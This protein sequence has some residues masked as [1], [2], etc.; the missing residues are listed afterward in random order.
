M[1]EAFPVVAIGGSVGGLLSLLAIVRRLPTGFPGAILVVIHFPAGQI[2]HLD[3]ILT[4]EGSLPATVAMDHEAIQPGHIYVAP[5]DGCHLVVE[6]GRLHL[7]PGAK[8]HRFRPAIDP[9]FRSAAR[10]FGSR[11]AGVLLSGHNR[12]GVGGLQSVQA[13]GGV[14]IVQDPAEATV[15]RLPDAALA[16]MHVDHCSSAAEIAQHLDRWA[17]ARLPVFTRGRLP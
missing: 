8:E 1:E 14:A 16:A 10:A 11:L 3:K 17:A 5:A 2:S 12:D 6:R 15:R 7:W 4:R 9:L 13:A